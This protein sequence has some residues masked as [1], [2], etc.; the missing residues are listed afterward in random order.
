MERTL[1]RSLSDFLTDDV[2]ARAGAI[3]RSG[4]ADPI[5]RSMEY[6]SRKVKPGSFFFA[7]PGLRA[8]G[9]GFV[10]EAVAAGAVAVAHEADVGKK[11]P[12]VVYVRVK[13]SRFSMSPISAAF[14]GYP[15]RR[16]LVAG[17]T[18]TD[19]KSTTVSLIWQ[20][21]RLAGKKAGFFSTVQQSDGGD[22]VWNREPWTTP[23][24]P[25]V[26]RLLWEMAENGCSFAV[27]ESSSHALSPRTNR[28]G[29]VEYDA[30]VFTNLGREHLEFHGTWER[31][32]DDKANL[33][34]ALDKERN[35]SGAPGL[36]K[37][38]E[39]FG[40]V[41]ADDPNAPYFAAA[42]RRATLGFSAAGK[43]TDLTATVVDSG[44]GGNWLRARIAADDSVVE[45][46]DRLPGA[47]NAGN[48]L[49]ALLATSGLADVPI[50]ELAPLCHMLTPVRG[51][52]TAVK[53]GQPFEVL[54]DFAHTPS[55][56]LTVLPP[57]R[58]RV[59]E[60]GGRLFCLFGSA[61]ER[62]TGKRRE[63]G[64]AAA[65]FSDAIILTEDDPRGEDPM[66]II[67][68][69]AR[70]AL[71]GSGR[72]AFSVG[73]NLLKISNRREALKKAV[74]MAREGDIVLLLGK[75]HEDTMIY[76]DRVEPYDE[77]VEAAKAL[78]E[79]YGG[80]T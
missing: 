17:V 24:A 62:D 74:S 58:K 65:A 36:G 61:G 25:V 42:T 69:I 29:D 2:A 31:Y 14:Y 50:G 57:L 16:L 64:T 79:I 8:D 71:D 33:F 80:A 76:A 44:P 27:V 32:R 43:K 13:S 73:E 18:G 55:A 20:L 53:R 46:R 54:V 70:G 38:P 23:E 3:E 26:Q 40:V 72:A 4:D 7:L 68:E 51:R 47:F 6:D 67:D 5:V 52:M 9:H 49:A 48:V 39:P 66:D 35:K 59:D 37:I 75:G 28:L 30:T 77:V 56:F 22:A 41:N 63:M 34:R 15:S 11:A 45:I 12:G 19:G 10:E 60:A 78:D 21:L 1:E